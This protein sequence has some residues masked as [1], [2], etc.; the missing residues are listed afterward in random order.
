MEFFWEKQ[1][2][3]ASKNVKIKQK[4]KR[5]FCNQAHY[6]QKKDFIH[7]IGNVNIEQEKDNWIS[8]DE[9]YMYLTEE[10]VKA[11]GNVQGK[12]LIKEESG[13]ESKEESE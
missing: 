8:A 13:K 4:N 1:E 5:I 11:E 2:I 6:K 3:F 9:A 10:T 12:L 7:L